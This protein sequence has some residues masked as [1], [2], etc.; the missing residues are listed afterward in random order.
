M[1]RTAA[2]LTLGASLLAMVGT[3]IAPAAATAETMPTRS[4]VYS[5]LDNP[6]QIAYDPFSHSVF[7]AEA[8]HGGTTCD[9]A[10]ALCAGTTG[11]VARIRNADKSGSPRIT[12]TITGLPSVAATDGSYAS[13]VEGIT[14]NSASLFLS[15][16][17][18]P[19]GDTTGQWGKLL[20]AYA[21]SGRTRT[22]ADIAAYET[23]NDPD[24]LGAA[25]DPVAVAN[26]GSRTLV[27]DYAGNS[28]LAVT[29][30]RAVSVF[31]VLPP[32]VTEEGLVFANSPTALAVGVDGKVYVG[33][34]LGQVVVMDGAGAVVT[35][36]TGFGSITGVAAAA[37]GTVYVSDQADGFDE[38]GNVG[39]VV[40]IAAD[41]S[42][43]VA[44]V[45]SPAGLAAGK[46]GVFVTS[47]S[48]SPASSEAPG[49]LLW[50]TAAAFT[51]V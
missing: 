33:T 15:T 3:A 22:V 46:A 47:N 43:S 21:G 9:E 45:P 12:R 1:H 28:I 49:A 37:D 27:A 48:N 16:S 25:S 23:T 35:T 18:A 32:V 42:R 6:R 41:G 40:R 7:V 10:T 31:A 34:S 29:S 2:G 24:G 14:G 4:V 36:H 38:A 50:L 8:G 44:L 19:T 51:T 11:A 5:G 30:S 13:G 39:Q 17:T 26:L 20:V